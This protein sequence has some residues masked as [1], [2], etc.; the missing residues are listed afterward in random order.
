MHFFVVVEEST[1]E[2]GNFSVDG[3][4]SVGFTVSVAELPGRTGDFSV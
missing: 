1:R 3:N 4:L 2:L